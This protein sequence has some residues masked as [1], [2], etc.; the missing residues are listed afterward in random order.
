MGNADTLVWQPLPL[1]RATTGCREGTQYALSVSTECGVIVRAEWYCGGGFYPSISET[2]R[3]C[4]AF[5]RLYVNS[6]ADAGGA[7][8]YLY[9]N[10]T[11]RLQ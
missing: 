2:N 4:G 11:T 8:I 9:G 3:D 1:L 10:K 7:S 5:A 6:I